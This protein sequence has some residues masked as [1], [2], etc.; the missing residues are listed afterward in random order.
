ML[1][2]SP[3]A[4]VRRPKVS[5]DSSTAGLAADELV[6]LLDADAAHS[7]RSSALVTLLAYNGVRTIDEALSADVPDYT[8]QRGYR[9][10]H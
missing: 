4:N 9:V 5:E 7:P 1:A 10:L 2:F 6:R 3:V 8:F